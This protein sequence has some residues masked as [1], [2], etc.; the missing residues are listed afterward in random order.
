MYVY[1]I[2]AMHHLGYVA[3]L[4]TLSYLRTDR[5]GLELS[6]VRRFNSKSVS[7]TSYFYIKEQW[8]SDYRAIC[9]AVHDNIIVVGHASGRISLIKLALVQCAIYCDNGMN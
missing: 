3:I 1:S 8:I 2:M 4:T 5:G 6:R 9:W 7:D